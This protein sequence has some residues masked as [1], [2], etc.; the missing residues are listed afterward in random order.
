[1]DAV[2]CSQ[3]AV[4]A[5]LMHYHNIIVLPKMEIVASNITYGVSK[6]LCEAKERDPYIAKALYERFFAKRPEAL[7]YTIHAAQKEDAEENLIFLCCTQLFGW[8]EIAEPALLDRY[9]H[10]LRI[11][12]AVKYPEALD[13]IKANTNGE[14]AAQTD[15]SQEINSEFQKQ[16]S[17][18]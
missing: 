8:A 14:E 7:P 17:K 16:N 18:M 12:G 1:M 6:M 2:P 9:L 4:W 10:K 15:D 11:M 5:S 3:S 13:W